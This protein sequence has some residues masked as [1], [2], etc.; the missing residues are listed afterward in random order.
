MANNTGKKFPLFG[1]VVVWDSSMAGAWAWTL[2]ISSWM[3]QFIEDFPFISLQP[4]GLLL[5]ESS[6]IKVKKK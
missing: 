2:G 5:E 1:F 6:K 4:Y 3:L